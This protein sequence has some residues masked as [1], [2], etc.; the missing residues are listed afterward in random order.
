MEADAIGL[1]SMANASFCAHYPLKKRYPQPNPKPKPSDWRTAG[2]L[3]AEGEVM[4]RLYVGYYVGDYDAPSWVYKAVPAFFSDPQRG[5]VPLGWSFDPNL[6]DRA[7]Q[8]LVYA[9]RHATTNDFFITGDS[10]AGYL[11]ARA[12]TDRP[13]SK[14]PPAL[15]IWA[16]HCERYYQRWDMTITGFLLDGAAGASTELEFSV[17]KRFSPDGCGNHFDLAPRII[18]GI[19]TIREWDMP[20]SP[21]STAAYMANQAKAA[22]GAPRFLW[23]RTILKSPTW[24]AEVSRALREKHATAPVVVVDPYTFFG[25][26]REHVNGKRK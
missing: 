16:E 25:L 5:K 10:G 7:P 20:E 21:E 1:S 4:P 19:P 2:Y 13:D 18:S 22:A 6:A 12:L 9:Y 26:I 14:L 11:N 15:K 23:A 24:H 8:A 17:Y 3:T